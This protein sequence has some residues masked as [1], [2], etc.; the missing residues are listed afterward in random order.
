M[1]KN[2]M[3][4]F[5]VQNANKILLRKTTQMFFIV[6]A[7]YKKWQINYIK[8][9]KKNCKKK[10]MKDIKIFLKKKKTKDEKSPRNIS[11]SFWG[12]RA[13]GTWVYQKLLFST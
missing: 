11:K 3:K 1:K 4:K 7:T 10:H 8:N 6:F 12:T 13:E 5:Q 9:T 2:L